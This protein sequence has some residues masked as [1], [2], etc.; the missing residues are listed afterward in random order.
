MPEIKP[1][2]EAFA[3]IKVVGIGGSGGNAIDHMVRSKLKGVDFISINT[4]AQDLHHSLAPKKIHIGKNLTRGLGAGMNP[5]IGRQAAEET[6]DEV[7]ETLKGADMVFIAGGF[8]GGTCTGA[9]PIVARTAKEQGALTIAVVTRPFVFEGAQ[10]ARI[11]EE[12]LVQLREAVDAVIV[13]PNDRLLE[14]AGKET[15][16]L[17]A[18][19]LCDEVLRQAV[20]GI[21]DLIT[22]PGIVN[23]DFADVKAILKDAGSAL[24][25][26]GAASGEKRAEKAAH[27]AINS[28][29]L[30]V[31]IDGAKGVLFSVAGGPDL[32]MWEVQ[33]A[34]RIITESIDKDAKVIFGAVNDPSLKKN[35]LRV[36]VIA[37]GFHEAARQ[38]PK[39]F[40]G[41]PAAEAA[42]PTGYRKEFSAPHQ[43][44]HNSGDN[45]EQNGEWDAI[46]AFL[47]RNKK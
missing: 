2:V 37:S 34:A 32:G 18:F 22:M 10:R 12:G 1:A 33:E 24:M 30:D 31:T 14:V 19:A 17:Q 23:V 25:G 46:P 7:Q 42:N 15:T 8:G 28:A 3:R 47:R 13:V 45:A 27:T 26:I 21:S 38:T 39:P 35:E 40:L 20:Q 6:R 11:A 16:F 43:R 4:D 5:E 36:T 29:L 44:N 9:A 41:E